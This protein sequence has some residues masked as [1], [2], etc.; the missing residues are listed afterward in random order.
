MAL[1]FHKLTVK[2]VTQETPDA[3]SVTF[4]VPADLKNEFSFTQGQSITIR[5][6][7]NGE[8]V[9]RSYSICSSPLDNELKIGIKKAYNGLFSTYANT[10]LKKGD[11]LEVMPPS[12]NFFTALHPFN[13]KAYMAFAAGS[14]ITPVLS[15]IKTTLATEPGSTFNLIFAN[16]TQL[17]IM[18]KEALE[19][20]K[21]KYIGRFSIC[22]ILSREKTDTDVNYGRIDEQKCRQLTKL[23]NLSEIDDFFICGPNEMIF[24]VKKFLQNEGISN[25]N[26]HFE[27]F[28]TPS[29]NNTGLHKEA[30]KEEV[31][32]TCDITVK[33][34]GRTF[35]FGLDY[36][37]SSILDAA[38]AQGADLP[39]SCKG[40]I[41]TTCKAKL[42]EGAVEMEVNYGLEEDEVNAGFILTCQSHPRTSKVTVDYDLR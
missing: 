4:T 6:T 15:I 38:L 8:E 16:R 39:F 11:T 27:L 13:K 14:G 24:C 32:E 35:S 37:G 20:L 22:Y 9:R 1:H 5:K 40:G 34:D 2:E 7:L 36:T 25:D 42:V 10:V 31:K 17:S 21:D 3:V 33:L 29:K 26:I 30:A 12:G 23:I 41:C 28:T 18:F 19:A